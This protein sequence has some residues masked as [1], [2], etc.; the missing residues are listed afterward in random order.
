LNINRLSTSKQF[1]AKTT[2]GSIPSAYV[3]NWGYTLDIEF[4]SGGLTYMN[5]NG[6]LQ[7]YL[8]TNV[9]FHSPAEHTFDGN[10]PQ[11]VEM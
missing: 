1:W 11:D 2:Y 8:I 3:N 6:V 7:S 5:E 10:S 9:Q 4:D